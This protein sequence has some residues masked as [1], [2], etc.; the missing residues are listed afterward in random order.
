LVYTKSE[1]LAVSGP[2]L[3]TSVSGESAGPVQS[4][5]VVMSVASH[6]EMKHVIVQLTPRTAKVV[7]GGNA[8]TKDFTREIGADEAALNAVEGIEICKKWT[9]T[10]LS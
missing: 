7:I 2:N 4:A 8:V 9:A 1:L 10:N 6:A 3:S 5:Y